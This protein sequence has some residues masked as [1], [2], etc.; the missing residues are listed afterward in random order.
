V[1]D[2]H[3]TRLHLTVK[4]TIVANDTRLFLF[5]PIFLRLK[6]KKASVVT[7]LD[8]IATIVDLNIRGSQKRKA[9][10]DTVLDAIVTIVNLSTREVNK[11]I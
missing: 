11:D 9:S 7:V 6:K 2:L 5:S 3:V 1:L 4:S 10:A 8:A